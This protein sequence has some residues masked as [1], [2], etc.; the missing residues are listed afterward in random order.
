MLFGAEES[1]C[2]WQTEINARKS[3]LK[4]SLG[5]HNFPLPL[6]TVIICEQQRI[7]YI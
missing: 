5:P 1:N 2:R 4:Q 6:A 3:I 7:N